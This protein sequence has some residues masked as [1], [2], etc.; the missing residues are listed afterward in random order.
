MSSLN[1]EKSFLP[2]SQWSLMG[3]LPKRLKTICPGGVPDGQKQRI[4]GLIRS[5]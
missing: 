3:L 1:Q 4:N 5:Y 2:A